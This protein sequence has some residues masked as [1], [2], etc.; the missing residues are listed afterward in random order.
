MNND[1][2][3]TSSDD[4]RPAERWRVVCRRALFNIKS[5]WASLMERLRDSAEE[6]FTI[7]RAP[8]I[9]AAVGV[10]AILSTAIVTTAVALA[11]PDGPDKSAGPPAIV[12]QPGTEQREIITAAR[13]ELGTREAGD[14]CQKYS[15]QCVAWCALFATSMWGQAGVDVNSDKFAFTGDLYTTGKAKGTAYAGTQLQQARP[16]DALLFGTGPQSPTT[17]K[18][19][20]VVEKVQGNTVTLIEGNTG[21]NP[22]RVMRK[23]HK[24]SPET[25]Y[26]GVHPW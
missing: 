10:V 8:S 15:S 5:V 23:E 3:M 9:A 12:A 26:G 2:D 24:L 13:G 20:G 1:S 14:N 21:D 19:V 7:H 22:D 11:S 17:S 25:F 16:G 4:R 6:P 18:H